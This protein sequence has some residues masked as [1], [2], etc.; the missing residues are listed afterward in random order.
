MKYYMTQVLILL[1]LL[2]W[3]GLALAV[4]S[5]LPGE[6]LYS[7]KGLSRLLSPHIYNEAIAACC[8]RYLPA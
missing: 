4:E 7:Q 8:R 3:K 5:V 6:R 1:E 2:L